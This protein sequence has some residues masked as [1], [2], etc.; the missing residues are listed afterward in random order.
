VSDGAWTNETLVAVMQTHITNVVTHFKGLCYAWTVVNEAVDDY[1]APGYR[2]SV[3]YNTIGRAY[4]GLAFS[5][6]AAA[7][8]D[9]KLYYNDYNIENVPEKADAVVKIV[10]D[11]QALGI[12]IDGVGLQG[13]QVVGATPER[14]SLADTL[15]KF[16]ALGLEVAWTEIEIRH[17]QLPPSESALQQQSQDYA[18]MVGACL[19]VRECVGVTVWQFT[20]K[21][22]WVPQSFETEGDACLWSKDYQRRPA[23]DGIM[24]LLR[25]TILNGTY[26]AKTPLARPS[27]DGKSAA[28]RLSMSTMGGFLG[29]VFSVWLLL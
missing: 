15:R 3:F 13:H 4:I 9:A 27:F 25:A 6:A 8:E 17:S 12:K 10:T 24:E 1:P 14:T 16:A 18:A 5:A 26:P 28:G 22:N 20:D 21:Y 11:V 7:D 19:D 2:E 29:A 23:Y